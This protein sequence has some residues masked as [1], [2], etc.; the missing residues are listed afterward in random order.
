MK[1]VGAIAVFVQPAQRKH[2]DK[3]AVDVKDKVLHQPEAGRGKAAAAHVEKKL[4]GQQKAELDIKPRA[5]IN[6]QGAFEIFLFDEKI[7]ESPPEND[8]QKQ[9]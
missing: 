2:R 5:E 9:V 3:D 1:L 4:H 6:V 7:K 8:A